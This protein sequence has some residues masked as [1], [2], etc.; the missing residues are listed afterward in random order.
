MDNTG[1]LNKSLEYLCAMFND[2]RPQY[3]SEIAHDLMTMEIRILAEIMKRYDWDGVSISEHPPF[4]ET[5][6]GQLVRSTIADTL[7]G[8]SYDIPRK[9]IES[10]TRFLDCPDRFIV[11][12]ALI[13]ISSWYSGGNRNTSLFLQGFLREPYSFPVDNEAVKTLLERI[14]NHM[15][16]V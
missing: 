16:K 13:Y 15:G 10:A 14:H 12:A 2:M 5:T 6:E 1:R 11:L 3:Q 8:V 4:N 7:M 9:I